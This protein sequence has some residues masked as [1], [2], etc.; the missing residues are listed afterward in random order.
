MRN[1]AF[2]M[3]FLALTLALYGQSQPAKGAITGSVRDARTGSPIAGARITLDSNFGSAPAANLLKPVTTSDVSGQFGFQNAE[4]GQ[5][6]LIVQINGYARTEYGQK[7]P[8]GQG[9]PIRLAPGQKTSGIDIRLPATGTIGGRVLDSSGK[10]ALHVPVRLAQSAYDANGQHYLNVKLSTQSDD[11]GEYRFYYVTPGNYIVAAGAIT[12]EFRD[13]LGGDLQSTFGVSFL[14]GTPDL[15]RAEL[16]SIR[17]GEELR[18]ADILVS[19]S[20][21]YAIQGRVTD[22]RTAA[23]PAS[24]SVSL[25]YQAIDRGG[26]SGMSVSENY[27]PRT[28]GFSF[29]RLAPGTYGVA[30]TF[31]DGPPR[32]GGPS[33]TAFASV[34]IVNSDIPDL[35][36]K[37]A[38]T[39]SIGAT[40]R[41][42]GQN[43]IPQRGAG[44]QIQPLP[45]NGE[46]VSLMPRPVL[47][48]NPDGTLSVRLIAGSYRVSVLPQAMPPGVYVKELRFGDTDVWNN[49]LNITGPT[50]SKL[51]LVFSTKSAQLEGTVTDAQGQPAEPNPLVLVPDRNRERTE[52]YR[53]AVVDRP[54]HFTISNVPP[55][56]YKL[57]AWEA[58]EPFGYFDPNILKRDDTKAISVHLA[59]SAHE[60]VDLHLIPLPEFR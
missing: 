8:S 12:G 51:E 57:F 19:R 33:Y 23:P 41:V 9:T 2:A 5:Y 1:A 39:F 44:V 20:R 45:S 36:L 48:P 14:P 40:I 35:V 13:L 31:Q 6:R 58:L 30:A 15:E 55:G 47:A 59:E 17:S 24:A 54:G 18:G 29:G 16:V 43:S 11:R 46:S 22:N 32:G 38:D 37:P 10:P 49:P 3:L 28:G 25:L 42:D 34:Q 7:I 21:L 60:H 27:D 26:I 56:D 52:L 50:E 4:P 53:T